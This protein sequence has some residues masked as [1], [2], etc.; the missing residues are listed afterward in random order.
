MNTPATKLAVPVAPLLPRMEL[1]A[2]GLKLLDG[3]ADA[4]MGMARLEGAG[5]MPDAARIAAHA[6]PK[7]EAIWWACMCA[8]AIPDPA[9]KP[10]DIAA[11]EAAEAWVRRPEEKSRRAAMAAAEKA[12]FAS[13]E[14]WAAVA[15]FW[16][17][18]S[19]APE[20]QADVPPADHLTGG[21]VTGAVLLAAVRIK[22]ER[23][24]DRFA[25][26]LKSAREIAEG[27]GGRIE[28][29]TVT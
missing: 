15:V 27:G 17:G 13:A 1:D 14:A 2:E 24:N 10:E 8:R 16:S 9:G 5:R 26:F 29:E 4:A 7:R 28:P 12:K 19:L 23:Q 20:G 3:A 6:L 18:G 21:A 22:P 25:R 11:L